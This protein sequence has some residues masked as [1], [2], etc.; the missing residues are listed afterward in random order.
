MPA[1]TAD[2]ETPTSVL[3][4]GRFSLENNAVDPS[5]EVVIIIRSIP[6]PSPK[7]DCLLPVRGNFTHPV[8]VIGIRLRHTTSG[9]FWRPTPQ[10]TGTVP[11][12]RPIVRHPDDV[13]VRP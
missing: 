7:L 11:N 13:D 4:T 3:V 2:I 10:L 8:A 9:M 12:P 5:A 1:R 6:D